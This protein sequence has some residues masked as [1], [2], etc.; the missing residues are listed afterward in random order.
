MGCLYDASKAKQNLEPAR[1]VIDL[2]IEKL[3]NDWKRLCNFEILTLQLNTFEKYYN[4]AIS[5]SS[6]QFNCNTWYWNRQIK[7]RN[8]RHFKIKKRGK[9]FC[10]SVSSQFWFWR[11]GNFFSILVS[12]SII[13]HRVSSILRSTANRVIAIVERQWRKV[14]TA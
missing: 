4:L 9:E 8:S 11:Y 10:K 5:A 1:S 2:H 7:R 13:K 3:S 12:V 14:R 6:A